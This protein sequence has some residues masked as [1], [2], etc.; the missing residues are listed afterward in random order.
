MNKSSYFFGQSVFGQ[1]ISLIDLGKINTIARKHMADHYVK[2]FDTSDHLISMLFSTF[3]HC[4]SL[5]EVASSMLG[6]KGKM[7]KSSMSSSTVSS[8]MSRVEALLSQLVQK[9]DRPVQVSVEMDGEKVAKGVGN[10]S[11]KLGT[12]MSTNTY[13]IQ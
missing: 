5:R 1:L 9:Q 10:N 2:K 7:N 13:K 11:T 3:A 4:T 8:D 6:L 12:S